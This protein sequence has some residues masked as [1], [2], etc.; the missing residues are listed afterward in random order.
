MN[1]PVP[2]QRGSSKPSKE[3]KNTTDSKTW[4]HNRCSFHAVFHL[5]YHFEAALNSRTV[6]LPR[7]N[8]NSTEIRVLQR[9]NKWVAVDL[10]VEAVS[11]NPGT[12]FSCMLSVSSWRPAKLCSQAW[13]EPS[14]KCDFFYVR[15]MK[16]G[17]SWPRAFSKQ[18]RVWTTENR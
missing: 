13:T 15:C 7:A 9:V 4:V 1:L 17:I 18:S 5:Q 11:A 10:V 14:S 16:E 2:Q 3:W 6:N 12:E 8:L